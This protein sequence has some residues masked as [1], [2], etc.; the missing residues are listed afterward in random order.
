MLQAVGPQRVGH[1][2]SDGKTTGFLD[3]VSTLGFFDEPKLFRSGRV[4]MRRKALGVCVFA[5]LLITQHCVAQPP[6]PV[7]YNVPL[8]LA[9]ISHQH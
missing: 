9:F 6:S 3:T 2:L 1:N 8:N 5:L 7:L 4:W